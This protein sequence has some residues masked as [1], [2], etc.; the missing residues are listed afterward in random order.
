MIR[1]NAGRAEVKKIRNTSHGDLWDQ[2]ESL[3]SGPTPATLAQWLKDKAEQLGLESWHDAPADIREGEG[4]G[5][6][7]S[8]KFRSALIVKPPEMRQQVQ[9]PGEIGAARV[10][11]ERGGLERFQN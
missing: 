9:E 10:R 8:G 11:R 2:V 4:G 7:A 5:V 1:R 3:F 6:H